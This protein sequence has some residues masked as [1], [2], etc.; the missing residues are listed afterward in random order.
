KGLGGMMFWALSNDAEGDASL[1]EAADDLLRQGASYAEVI[2]RAPEF[3][4]IVGGDGQFGLD[5]FLL[6]A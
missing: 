2:G 5:D 6:F 3:D 4:F 1:V